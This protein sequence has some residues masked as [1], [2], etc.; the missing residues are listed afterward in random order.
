MESKQGIQLQK[1]EC[2]KCFESG[3]ENSLSLGTQMRMF[4]DRIANILA[5]EWYIY[6]Y[7]YK[8]PVNWSIKG[9]KVPAV[10]MF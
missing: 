4:Y 10:S 1:Q 7:M 8:K 3:E 2:R 9:K 6:I 5:Y